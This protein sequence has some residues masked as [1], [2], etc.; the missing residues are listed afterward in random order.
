M[1]YNISYFLVSSDGTDR[2]NREAY[3]KVIAKVFR[4]RYLWSTFNTINLKLPKSL[5]E[6][7]TSIVANLFYVVSSVIQ[8]ITIILDQDRNDYVNV[9]ICYYMI[10]QTVLWDWRL[11]ILSNLELLCTN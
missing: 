2:T 3:L 5:T 1:F 4:S 11:A 10:P 6:N 7:L 9:V 8:V